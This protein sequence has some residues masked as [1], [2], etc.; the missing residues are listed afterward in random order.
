MTVCCGSTEAM[1]VVDAGHHQ[2]GRRS[3]RLRALL[4]KLWTGHHSLRCRA[5][6]RQAASARIGASIRPSWP[7]LSA[8]RPRRSSS[9]RRTIPR[10]KFSRARS[11]KCIRDLCVRW[12]A[13]AITDEIYE[14][15]LYDGAKHISLAAVDGMRDRTI[16]INALSKTY[17]VTGWRVG[18]AIADAGS[19]RAQ[20]A[21]C[22]TSSPWAA[23]PLQE[24][25]AVALQFPASYYEKLAR[26]Y[27]VRRD[28]LLG[29][30]TDAG[31][32]CL[33]P[34]G[35]YYIMADISAF[36][37]PDDVSFARIW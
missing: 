8:P 16:T 3:D 17:S 22:T 21:R 32:R 14:H 18:W 36:G 1:I 2:S 24:A 37:F 25:G 20:S 6:L 13:F 34:R 11:S 31:F 30:L 9:I 19:D 7:R 4:R 29:I 5:A 12:N 35:A 26:D 33:K 27:T 28:R 23:A 10:A 15:I